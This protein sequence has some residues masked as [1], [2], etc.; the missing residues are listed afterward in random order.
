MNSYTS[1][2]E[3][4]VET[5]WGSA[6]LGSNTSVTTDPTDFVVSSILLTPEPLFPCQ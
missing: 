4:S 1:H 6:S 2:R 3:G 5:V